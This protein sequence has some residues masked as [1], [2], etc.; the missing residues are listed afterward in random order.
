[1]ESKGSPLI[2]R[3]PPRSDVGPPLLGG[4]ARRTLS[5]E[6][7]IGVYRVQSTVQST[8]TVGDPGMVPRSQDDGQSCIRVGRFLSELSQAHSS[9][10]L[11]KSVPAGSRL[12]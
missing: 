6:I 7:R 8:S 2:P 5:F 3:A 1:M 10:S 9:G 4:I 11:V 12:S